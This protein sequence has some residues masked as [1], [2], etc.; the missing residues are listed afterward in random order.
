ML[1]IVQ[2]WCSPAFPSCIQPTNTILI[3]SLSSRPHGWKMGNVTFGF[4]HSLYFS[5]HY[6]YLT[7]SLYIVLHYFNCCWC[8]IVKR[9]KIKIQKNHKMSGIWATRSTPNLSLLSWLITTTTIKSS[10]VSKVTIQVFLKCTFS[11]Y[12]LYKHP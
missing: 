12:W 7:K 5:K 11:H 3:L 6:L 9:T 1:L 10:N 2:S 4:S 8:S